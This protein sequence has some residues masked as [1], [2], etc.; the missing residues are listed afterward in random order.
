MD[1][2]DL[3]PAGLQPARGLE[4][5][6]TAADDRRALGVLRPTRSSPRVSSQRAEAEDPGHQRAV[7]APARLRSAG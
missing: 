6:Q 4:P 5:E 3:E 1:D 2:V 7:V